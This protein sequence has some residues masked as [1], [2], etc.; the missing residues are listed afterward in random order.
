MNYFKKK[1]IY[2][3]IN[4]IISSI[5]KDGKVNKFE[6]DSKVNEYL[7]NVIKYV[8]F[9]DYYTLNDNLF[10]IITIPVSKNSRVL[11]FTLDELDCQYN[12]IIFE[13]D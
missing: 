6:L 3:E 8:F 13:E 4:N 9:L 11:P 5:Q 1:K 7:K 10:V 12:N 2:K